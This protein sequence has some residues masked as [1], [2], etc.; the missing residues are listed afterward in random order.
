MKRTVALALAVMSVNSLAFAEPV[1]APQAASFVKQKQLEVGV[2]AQY[3]Y[4]KSELESSV[5]TT[6]N[7]RVLMV[8]VWARYGIMDN[9][10]SHLS[11]PFV[12]AIDSSEGISSVHNE[13]GGLGNMQLGAK[14]NFKPAPL[15]LALG[16]DLDLPTANS[17][18]NV[19]ATGM[20]Y[21]SQIQQGFNTHLFL[22]ADH[23]LVP[24][25]LMAHGSI[26]YMNTATYT[27]AG[28]SRFNPSDLLTYSA[29]LELDMKKWVDGM[30]ASGELVGNTA[31]THSRTD[32][33]VDGGHDMG[34]VIE[35]GPA[36]RYQKGSWRTKLGVLF[37][38]GP[39]TYRAYNY[40]TLF[41]VSYLFG[42]K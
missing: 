18:N 35:A 10:E 30:S 16:L 17:A 32:A 7:D 41:G 31:L 1:F 29:S 33:T 24:D 9:L 27:T 12:H 15:P 4:Q 42:G 40:R 25:L 5:G 23:A 8:P 19:A 11:L 34:Q 39:A 37:D 28:K 21:S 6:F 13:D 22:A 20:R 2:D 36:L 26:G 3:G 38:A 14:W